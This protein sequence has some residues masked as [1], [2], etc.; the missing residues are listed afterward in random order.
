MA[1]HFYKDDGFDFRVQLALGAVSYG[2]GDA[3]EILATI[4]HVKNGDD[5][6]WFDGFLGLGQRIEAVAAECAQSN[7]ELSARDAYLRAST[8]Y[9]YALEAVEGLKDESPLVP[10]FNQHRRCWDEFAKRCQPALEQVEIPYGEH[11]MPGYFCKVDDSGT[12]RPTLIVNNGSDA[13]I[14]AVWSTASA[15]LARGYNALLF[16]G[17][18]QQSMLFLEDVPFRPDWEAV[19][20]P[21]VDFLQDR[22]DV[23]SSKIALY[24]ISQAGYWVPRALAFEH[25]VAA[26]VADPGVVDVSSSWYANLP[27]H[28]RKLLSNGEAEKFNKDMDIGLK[29]SAGARREMQFRSRPYG[30]STH[31]EVFKAVGEYNV[32]P[33]AHQI[34][35]PIM[36]CDPE[37]EQFWPGQATELFD[38]ITGPKELVKFTAAEGADRHCEPM[39]RTLVDQR[40]FDWLATVL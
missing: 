23:D 33:V 13:S 5:Q 37:G 7:N 17:P 22:A 39:A 9:S 20:T 3:G 18:G 4:E 21:V 32:R 34:T 26:A 8:Y 11:K 2:L 35:T 38:L 24:G 16:D 19:I 31:F 12:A 27:S 15:A 28:L 10:T 14:T 36:I 6:A 30:M 29:F 40:M 25:R 1:Y